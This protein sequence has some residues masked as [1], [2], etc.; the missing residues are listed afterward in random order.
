MENRSNADFWEI[1]QGQQG[2]HGAAGWWSPE[3]FQGWRRV[4]FWRHWLQGKLH[5]THSCRSIPFTLSFCHPHTH[6]RTHTHTLCLQLFSTPLTGYREH[7][8]VR[9]PVETF[10]SHSPPLLTSTR[11]HTLLSVFVFDQWLQGKLH[12]MVW[13]WLIGFLK[14]QVSFAEYS[15]FL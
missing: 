10:D 12:G 3:I 1:L 2:A 13:L 4:C 7:C 11:T 15:L 9:T 6:T 5:G 8:T 14:L